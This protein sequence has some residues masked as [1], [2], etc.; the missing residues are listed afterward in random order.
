MM[1]KS[2]LI[3]LL[4]GLVLSA[5]TAITGAFPIRPLNGLAEFKQ[6]WEAGWTADWKLVGSGEQNID[7]FLPGYVLH[8][9][10]QEGAKH[11]VRTDSFTKQWEFYSAHEEFLDGG[12]LV[13]RGPVIITPQGEPL[14]RIEAFLGNVVVQEGLHDYEI[15]YYE[16]TLLDPASRGC[17]YRSNSNFVGFQAGSLRG[18]TRVPDDAHQVAGGVC[19]TPEA[20]RANPY[21]LKLPAT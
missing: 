3:P 10:R 11:W 4:L 13:S 7:E 5:V 16:L 1:R 18:L 15:L 21:K 14:F 12:R 6:K 9:A 8:W 17:V 20:L 2:N 19:P